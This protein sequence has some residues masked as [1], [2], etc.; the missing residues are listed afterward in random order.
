MKAFLGS[1]S[2]LVNNASGRGLVIEEFQRPYAWGEVQIEA[3]FKDQFEPLLSGQAK[4]DNPFLGAIVLL[5][6]PGGRTSVVDGQQRLLTLGLII[7]YCSKVLAAK[8]VE[9]PD[10]ARRFLTDYRNSSWIQTEQHVNRDSLG[11]A[12]RSDLSLN[13]T[14]SEFS[15]SSSR[16]A[17]SD[18]GK[19]SKRAFVEQDL[20]PR[21]FGL[22]R[23]QIDDF[24]DSFES[25]SGSSGKGGS[26]AILS[27]LDHLIN[28]LQVVVVELVSHEQSLAVFEALNAAGQPLSLDQLVKCLVLKLFEKHD[29]TIAKYLHE[30]WSS[31]VVRGNISFTRKLKTPRAREQ[32]LIIY[33]NAFID[34][35]S[36]RSAYRVLKRHFE[37]L[38]KRKDPAA[39]CR[40]LIDDMQDYWCFLAD[41][42]FELFR[43]GGEVMIPTIFASRKALVK[44]GYSGPRLDDALNEIVFLIESGFARAHFLKTPKSLLSS[45]AYRVNPRLIRARDIGEIRSLISEFFHRLRVGGLGSDELVSKAIAGHTFKGSSKVAL[46]MLRR[47]NV[48]LRTRYSSKAQANLPTGA[49]YNLQVAKAYNKNISDK[50]LVSLGYKMRGGADRVIYQQL[51]QSIGNYLFLIQGQMTGK[52]PVNEPWTV[53]AKIDKKYL[54]TRRSWIARRAVMVWKI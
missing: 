50:E 10:Y 40:R 26:G 3:L 43:F 4:L 48:G 22:I 31:N 35:A 11:A 46:L 6:Q 45:A 12:M 14:Y 29:V 21:A 42:D 23:S 44:L 13:A 53:S 18:G 7:G 39:E 33:C 28:K 25:S 1:L 47:I 20:V 49:K 36:K 41:C 8:R 9:V 2:S 5:P 24:V 38:A 54:D 16:L 19:P 32:F 27:L 15:A 51:S 30:A 37:E 17:G 34:A 52:I